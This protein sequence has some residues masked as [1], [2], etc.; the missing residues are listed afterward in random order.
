MPARGDFVT[1]ARARTLVQ[2]LYD[3]YDAD[4]A[5]ERSKR[6]V[7]AMGTD[8]QRAL[9]WLRL[10]LAD[11]QGTRRQLLQ[12]GFD[13]AVVDAAAALVTGRRESMR[14]YARR[15]AACQDPDALAVA[16]VAL[17]DESDEEAVLHRD[18]Q[19]ACKAARRLLARAVGA[20]PP[21]GPPPAGEGADDGPPAELSDEL[22]ALVDHAAGAQDAMRRMLRDPGQGLRGCLERLSPDDRDLLVGNLHD[23]LQVVAVVVFD[24]TAREGEDVREDRAALAKGR[25]GGEPDGGHGDDGADDR[26]SPAGGAPGRRAGETGRW[27]DRGSGGRQG[28]FARGARQTLGR[29]RPSMTSDSDRR[30]THTCWFEPDRATSTTSRS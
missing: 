10:I 12:L 16:V 14:A 3:E 29:R 18:Q 26:A 5:F 11:E 8:R 17:D 21:E 19:A 9:V 15:I 23:L 20:R 2:L 30:T 24:V 25:D 6:V 27:T 4:P 1:A 22:L 28:G 7:R 13:R